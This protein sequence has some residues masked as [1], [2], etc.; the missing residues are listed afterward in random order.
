[1]SVARAQKVQLIRKFVAGLAAY[2]LALQLLLPSLAL[3]QVVSQASLHD[4]LCASEATVD[5]H[6]PAPVEH[7]HV[8]PCG[9]LCQMQQFG[10]SSGSA[11]AS[12]AFAWV[13]LSSAYIYPAQFVLDR[14]PGD[15]AS[16]PHNPRA[17][18]AA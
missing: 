18:P 12:Y 10:G 1:V 13:P 16:T 2:G 15:L 17:P 11:P 8:C 6:V 4:A 14:Q 5:A 3:A 9:P 7:Q